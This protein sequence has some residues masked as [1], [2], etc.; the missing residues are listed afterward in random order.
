MPRLRN[1]ESKVEQVEINEPVATV[2][3]A[4]VVA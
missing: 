1:G 4:K 2:L 3:V